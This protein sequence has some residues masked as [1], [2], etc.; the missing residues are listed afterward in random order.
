MRTHLAATEDF[1]VQLRSANL[2]CTRTRLAVLHHLALSRHPVTHT[3]AVSALG[4]GFDR[5]SIYR[6]LTDLTRARLL[7][8]SDDGDHVWR[9]SLM[10]REHSGDSWRPHFVCVHCGAVISISEKAIRI[11]VRGRVPRS[12][13]RETRRGAD[14]G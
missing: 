3:E 6:A 10:R 13:S 7:V 9:F 14:K 8:R 2:S 12:L 5:V 1:E 4:S 11:S